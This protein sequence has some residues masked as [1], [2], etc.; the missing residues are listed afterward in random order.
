MLKTV[1]AD[2]VSPF[3][4]TIWEPW[5]SL[6]LTT[7]VGGPYGVGGI[8][9]VEVGFVIPGVGDSRAMCPPLWRIT[10]RVSRGPP[11]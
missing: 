8:R 11:K 4:F 3:S 9:A 1:L 7:P 5:L 10:R 6:A 2:E